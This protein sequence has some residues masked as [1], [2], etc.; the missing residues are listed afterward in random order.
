MHTQE[1]GAHIN[2]LFGT[3]VQYQVPRYQRRY[4]WNETN[5]ETLW[6]DI[7]AQEKLDV[8]A[9]GHFTGPIV[10][11]SIGRGQLDRYEVIDGQ[12]RL[13]TFQIILC[14]IRDLCV[15]RDH[16]EL[17][18]EATRHIVNTDDVVRRNNLKEFPY[19]FLPTDYDKPFF[20]KVAAGEYRKDENRVFDVAN[21]VGDNIFRAYAYFANKITEHVEDDCN[22]DKISDL[23]SSIKNDFT[24]VPITLETSDHPEKVFES[25]NA[26]GRMLS[27][28]DY[29][30][31]N[32]FLRARKLEK[33]ENL[34]KSYSDVFY[35]TYWCFEDTSLYWDAERLESFLH[36]FLMAKLGLYCFEGESERAKKAFDIY[37]TYRKEQIDKQKKISKEKK[38]IKYEFQ[39][40]RD[41]AASYKEMTNPNSNIG[42]RMQFYHDLKIT[43]LRPFILYLK[44][45]LDR[46]D[47]EL[48]QVCD[49]L[50]SYI[51]RRMVNYGYGANDK[52][53][54]AYKKIGRF[55]SGL[56]AGEKFSVGDLVQFLRSGGSN[57]P[58]SWPTNTQIL[59]G[60]RRHQRSGVTAGGLQ[61]TADEMHFGKHSSQNAAVS[62]L[63]YIF[64]RI[65]RHINVEDTVS[66]ENFL[67]IPTR[68]TVL[69]DE[70]RDWRSIGNL[71]FRAKN[72]MDQED[73]NDYPFYMIKNI[74][75]EHLN[76]SVKLNRDICKSEDWG[77]EQIREQTQKLGSYFCEIWP[78]ANSFPGKISKR[79]PEPKTERL[80]YP[81]E[82]PD[83]NKFDTKKLYE[84][85]VKY[86]GSHYSFSYIESN[87][88]SWLQHDIE[89]GPDSLDPSIL[90]GK[91]HP[92]LKVK[93][94]LKIIQKNG[95]LRFQADSL[96]LFTTEQLYQGEV[97]WVDEPDNRFGFLI[98]STYPDDIY[99]NRTQFCSENADPLKKGQ[100]LEFN[101]AETVEGKYPA[102]INVKPVK[103]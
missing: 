81:P 30:R 65:E 82:M 24:L 40:L 67:D 77:V 59:G 27:E 2:N 45:E 86:W 8:E 103:P 66:F 46:P 23:I 60:R 19:K 54:E 57:D 101:I 87:E 90:S 35:N 6:E 73:I 69:P 78:D 47:G 26:T 37:Q 44:N 4:V 29:L 5:W 79:V 88:L 74:L 18:A 11:R 70:G 38:K 52:D 22:Y 99:V 49:V 92:G 14:A 56:I 21:K 91:L 100:I 43:N 102:A 34:G 72:E 48:E 12:Q 7:L 89:A 28:F 51:L 98:S 55:F 96:T 13:V 1:K 10:T 3:D 32:L 42:Y 50:E 62:L 16:Q 94:K 68:L 97:K 85:V 71:T 15:L 95:R 58:S 64:Y 84:G 75:S 76:T 25:I 80:S 53:K 41:Y 61:R 31:N 83:D 20:E 33:D 39:Q 93:F 36:E 17:A 9:R 63:H